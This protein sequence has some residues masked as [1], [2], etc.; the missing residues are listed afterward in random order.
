MP[1]APL[2]PEQLAQA[3]ALAEAIRQAIDTEVQALAATL[4]TTADGHPFG[5]TEFTVRDRAHR[6]AAKAIEQHLARK[7]TATRGPA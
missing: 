6:I 4:V 3:Q 1:A 5:A 2:S 7:K